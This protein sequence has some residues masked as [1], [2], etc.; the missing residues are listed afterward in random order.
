[1]VTAVQSNTANPLVDKLLTLQQS[2]SN[3]YVSKLVVVGP[4]IDE[5][6]ARFKCQ[7]CGKCEQI[8][9]VVVDWPDINRLAAAAANMNVYKFKDKH[10]GIERPS[11]RMLMIQPCPF[12]D[13]KNCMQY[14]NRPKVCRLF[15]INTTLCTDGI[16]RIG[17]RK[18]CEAG[19]AFLK[20]FEQEKLAIEPQVKLVPQ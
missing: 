12:Y 15:P 10:V 7:Q 6:M 4:W 20:E 5:F 18:E 14:E 11:G 8:G 3:I 17:V 13:G 9:S 1:M 2:A 16:Y 19:I